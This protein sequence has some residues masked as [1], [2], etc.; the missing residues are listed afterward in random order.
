M[1][2]ETPR[3]LPQRIAAAI[4]TVRGQ[5]VMLD[6]DLASLYGVATKVLNQAV[7]RNM[8]R[9]PEDFVFKLTSAEESSLRS[10]IVTLETGRGR[11]RKYGSAAFT[12]QGVAMLSSVLRSK[13]A[14]QVNLQIIRAFVRLR[15]MAVTQVRLAQELERLRSRV[16]VHDASLDAVMQ[17]IGTLLNRPEPRPRR[18]GFSTGGPGTD[19]SN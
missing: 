17:V 3:D 13:T 2:K 19:N 16:D 12:E 4:Y 9:F 6:E 5:R 10:Q 11:H 1:S 7:K 15:E 14:I 18:I 8:E